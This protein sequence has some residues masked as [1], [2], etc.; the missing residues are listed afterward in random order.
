M[1][2][3][4][5]PT[6]TL[7]LDGGSMFGVVPKVLWS[8]VYP[9]DEN[10]LCTWAMRCLLVDAGDRKILIDNGAGHDHDEKFNTLYGLTGEDTLSESLAAY[11]MTTG[12]ITDVLLTHLH[13]DHCGGSVRYNEDRSNLIPAFHSA[14]YWVSRAQWE[15]AHHPNQR[16][17]A[18]FLKNIFT[19][20]SEYGN[21]QF[22]NDEGEL[23]PDI[24]VRFFNGHTHGQIIPFIRYRNTTVV[25][26]A[27]L[28]PS[29]AH[30]PLSWMLSFDMQP[31]VT[32]QEKEDFLNEA[33][34][35]QYILFLEHDIFHECCTVQ[36]TEKG[37]RLKEAF[38]FHE[39]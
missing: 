13:F 30:I 10:N 16:E 5:I 32:L 14:T 38:Y 2:L 21:I 33:A 36:R 22:I 4:T 31:M 19:S 39:T 35:N 34:D 6:G 18:S 23:F 12:D 15:N 29:T 25:F 28:I 3:Y 9:A 24:T 11:G 26:T 8:K 7:K 17:K 37:V 20:L 27:D 1:K